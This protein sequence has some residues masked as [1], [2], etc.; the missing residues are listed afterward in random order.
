MS[1]CRSVT[2][3][4]VTSSLP[5]ESPL[6]LPMYIMR[7]APTAFYSPDRTDAALIWLTSGFLEYQFSNYP[8]QQDKV[9]QIEF[10]FEICSEATR[11]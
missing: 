3:A 1:I 6:Q 8:L 4:T 11:L 2:T 9:T 10:S 7:T 5:A